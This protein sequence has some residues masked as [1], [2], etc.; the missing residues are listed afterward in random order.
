MLRNIVFVGNSRIRTFMVFSLMMLVAL[1]VTA[2]QVKADS[3]TQI[4]V[5]A[6][7]ED[8]VRFAEQILGEGREALTDLDKSVTRRVP[9]ETESEILCA[10]QMFG[11]GREALTTL[12]KIMI[13][14]RPDLAT[15]QQFTV[16]VF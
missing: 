8:E 9:A 16:Q 4:R 12:D 5:P 15:T 3:S 2:S 6:E 13:A 14:S 1:T 10:E 7:T 11:R